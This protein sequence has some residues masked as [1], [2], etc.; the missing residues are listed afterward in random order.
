M[1]VIMTIQILLL[2]LSFVL[3]YFGAE[4]ALEQAE[5]IGHYFKLSPLVIGVFLVGFGTSLP[6]FFVSQLACYRGVDDIA[7]GNVVGSNIS[8]IF[9]ILGISML[10]VPINMGLNE[11]REQVW[12][13]LGV[14][15]LLIV[16]LSRN[17]LDL[18]SS[19]LLAIFFLTYLY[20]TLRRMRQQEVGKQED[21]TDLQWYSPILLLIGFALL[22][23]GG[24]LLV[25]SG[26]YVGEAIGISKYVL[27]AI[28]VAFG[29]SFPELMTAIIACIK[30]KD[31]N[32]IVGNIIG[33][34]VFNIA[35]VLGSLGIYKV[36]LETSF[37][38]EFIV[39]IGMSLVFLM[40]YWFKQRW[41]KTVGTLF[42]LG[43]CGVVIWWV[44]YS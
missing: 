5:K 9:L 33:S 13:H 14:T 7:L 20:F 2:I 22:Y 31:V 17:Y 21:S 6:E 28:V 39:L 15:A 44:Y 8:N 43:Y 11:L 1:W 32:L 10:V 40:G 36:K 19:L 37:L 38:M 25:S 3:L 18:I 24:E 16:V 41:H 34:N 4:L 30:K 27:S 26:S 29:T 23:E 42:L 12:F 35:F